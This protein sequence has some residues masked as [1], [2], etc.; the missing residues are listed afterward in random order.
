MKADLYHCNY[1]GSVFSSEYFS[2][3]PTA[4]YEACC[5]NICK[6]CESRKIVCPSCNLWDIPIEDKGLVNEVFAIIAAGEDR[7]GLR[8]KCG[9]EFGVHEQDFT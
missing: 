4:E 1:C 8:C 2:Q 3:S 6:N 7:I 9:C 5:E